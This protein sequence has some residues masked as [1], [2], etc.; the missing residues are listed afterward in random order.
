MS[1]EKMALKDLE[2]ELVKRFLCWL[3]TDRGNSVATR[4]H[5]L[6]AIHSFV[7]YLQVHEPRL[8]LNSQR[9]LAILVKKTERKV[10]KPLTKETVATILHRPD[11]STVRGRRDTT[12]LC[13]LYDTACRVQG[14]CDLRVEDIRFEH[15]ANSPYSRLASPAYKGSDHY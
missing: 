8:L 4:N 9:I 13:V 6:V 11:I 1:I 2:P 15:P 3:E 10:I 7:R 12:I 14:L 5:L